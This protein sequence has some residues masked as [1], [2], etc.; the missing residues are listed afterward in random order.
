VSLRARQDLEPRRG[1][2]LLS[3]P[4]FGARETDMD[5]KQKL[6]IG[7]ALATMGGLGVVL[8]VL[9][10][11]DGIGGPWGFALGFLFGLSAGVGVA[12]AVSGMRERRSE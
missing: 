9:L 6:G 3:R 1:G 8:S 12:L 7:S 5:S 2:L 10:G 4:P 11:W